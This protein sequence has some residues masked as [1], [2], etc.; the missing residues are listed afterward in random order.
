MYAV[1]GRWTLD[2]AQREDQKPVLMERIVPGVR[3]LPGLVERYWAANAPNH[4]P[5]RPPTHIADQ[6]SE[7]RRSCCV[8]FG[9]NGRIGRVLSP[10]HPVSR[11]RVKGAPDH[12]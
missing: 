11:R 2:P 3:Q 6:R 10:G 9:T 4:G 8:E 1:V 5:R 12:R 7:L